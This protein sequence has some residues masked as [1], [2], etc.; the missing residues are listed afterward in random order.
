[1]PFSHQIPAMPPTFSIILP[2]R[3]RPELLGSAI[4]SVLRQSCGD[5]ELVISDNDSEE[6]TGTGELAATFQDP[7]IRYFRTSGALAMFENWNFAF[8]HATGDY[9]IVLEDKQR[10]VPNA[11][12]ILRKLIAEER[13]R[14]ISYLWDRVP[15]GTPEEVMRLRDPSPRIRQMTTL[16]LIRRFARKEI[17]LDRL[18]ACGMNSCIHRG[19]FDEILARNA[20][21]RV[22]NPLCPDI[23]FG[24]AVCACETEFW[25]VGAPLVYSPDFS[26]TEVAKYSN[27]YGQAQ[28]S[29]G[30]RDYFRTTGISAEE[31]VKD[32]PIKSEWLMPNI[33]LYDYAHHYVHIAGSTAP[34]INWRRYFVVCVV[35]T[36]HMSRM[37]A[38]IERETKSIWQAIQERGLGFK[39]CLAMDLA[40]KYLHRAYL[41]IRNKLGPVRKTMLCSTSSRDQPAT[42]GVGQPKLAME[43]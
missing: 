37:G 33:Y 35:Y 25:H 20:T 38:D 42:E 43:E 29:T 39:I 34:K 6:N 9:I 24:F 7:R 23:S 31:I 26:N 1:M 41:R 10:L 28:K 22:F 2:T 27:G 17:Y 18:F 21:G 8:A 30:A 13:P 5:F 4:E 32:V 11:L 3:N 16:S 14:V 19:V 36:Q 12:A 15:L 40:T